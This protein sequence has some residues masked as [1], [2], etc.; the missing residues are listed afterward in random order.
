MLWDE[1]QTA[2]QAPRKAQ[3]NLNYKKR[4]GFYP[5]S[6]AQ[7]IRA[8]PTV[9]PE[10]VKSV[11]SLRKELCNTESQHNY[12]KSPTLGFQCYFPTVTHWARESQGEGAR[13]NIV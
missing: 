13:L 8:A 9:L 12:K 7:D 3:S 6:D 2:A 4:M 11:P 10:S 1:R 5:K